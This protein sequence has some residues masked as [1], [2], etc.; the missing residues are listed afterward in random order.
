MGYTLTIGNAILAYY[1]AD[2]Y[3]EV[4]AELASQEGAP[5]H[6][7]FTGKGNSRSSDYSTWEGFC[8]EAGIYELFFGQGWG[9]SGGYGPCPDGFHRETPLLAKHPGYQPLCEAD[10]E[11]VKQARI[12]R[13]ANN[14]GLRPGFWD[15]ETDN[16][17]DGVLA[18]LLWLE[19]WIGW[20]LKN[21]E[22]PIIANS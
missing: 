13:E 22:I 14:G 15:D 4:G 8:K 5:D 3:L 11:F 20:A 10:Y 18:R 16:D 21:C 19:F 6:C 7:R 1:P 2:M 12:R 9:V 17:T